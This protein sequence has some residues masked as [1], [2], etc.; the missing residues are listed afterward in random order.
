MAGFDWDISSTYGYDHVKYYEKGLNASLGPASPKDAYLGKVIS[1]EWTNDLDLKRTFDI[2][3]AE[4]VLLD[5]GASFRQAGSQGVT[6]FLPS[7]SGT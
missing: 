6:G 4:P 7:G 2:G 5:I 1:S 3:T